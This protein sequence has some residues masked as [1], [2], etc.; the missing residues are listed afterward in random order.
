MKAKKKARKR[1][2]SK[3]QGRTLA[4]MMR[5]RATGGSSTTIGFDFWKQAEDASGTIGRAVED[6]RSD[7]YWKPVSL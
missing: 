7:R 4:E 3:R 1:G 2:A 6:S 5:A